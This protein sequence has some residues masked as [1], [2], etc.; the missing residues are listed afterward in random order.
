[1]RAV[2]TF[3]APT[4]LPWRR[5]PGLRGD[6][7]R[8]R[9]MPRRARRLV[10]SAADRDLEPLAAL[11][12]ELWGT[13][14]ELA[15]PAPRA[16]RRDFTVTCMRVLVAAC[17]IT[18]LVALPHGHAD[19]LRALRPGVCLDAPA[20]STFAD[21]DV[22]PCSS[23]HTAEVV[24]S[25]S[26]A[27]GRE[28]RRERLRGRAIELRGRVGRAPRGVHVQ[29]LR[30]HG[31]SDGVCIAILPGFVSYSLHALGGTTV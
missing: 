24:G 29:V 21:V 16:R 19:P 18:A 3:D 17:V 1:M 23:P 27:G 14:V 31:S 12:A 9:S 7:T 22:Q 20:A 15:M 4:T 6:L 26:D 13:P 25:T 28:R 5:I 10:L 11:L 8:G 30:D 2:I